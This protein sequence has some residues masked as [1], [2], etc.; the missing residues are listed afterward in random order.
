MKTVRAIGIILLLLITYAGGAF[1]HSLASFQEKLA[2]DEQYFEA[3]DQLAPKFEL[4]DRDGNFVG[5]ESLLGKVAVLFFFCA[6]CSG[7]GQQLETI[8]EVQDMLN[9]SAMRDLVQFVGIITDAKEGSIDVVWDYGQQFG[10]DDVNW[11][12]LAAT[13]DGE[14]QV[15]RLA[16]EFGHE[17]QEENPGFVVDN[18]ATHVIG[19]EGRWRGNFYG[20]NFNKTNLLIF[21]NA[22][23]NINSTENDGHK[24]D[25]AVKSG[26][27]SNLFG[28]FGGGS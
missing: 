21:I 25:S 24:E 1:A 28:F 3:M 14:R 16:A 5:N 12:V 15:R 10:L 13:G 23:I 8:A 18:M 19:I 27:W 17:I 26:F 11:T 9:I 7:A 20:V 22:L 6:E 2:R 4:M